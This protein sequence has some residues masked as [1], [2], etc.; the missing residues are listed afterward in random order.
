[1]TEGCTCHLG[2]A[3]CGWCEDTWECQACGKLYHEAD[4]D[5]KVAV[6]PKC[7]DEGV[8]LSHDQAGYEASR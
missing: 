1:M 6:C 7:R 5:Q 3:P 2:A 8:P 4:T